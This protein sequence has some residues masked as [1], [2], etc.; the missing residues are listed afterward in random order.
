[1]D[2][3]KKTIILFSGDLDK[4]LAAFIIANGAAASGDDVT[5]FFTFW[6]IN[7]VRKRQKVKAGGKTL[8]QSMFGRM[9]P[10]GYE[11][12]GLSKMN[13]LG[14]GAP[15]MKRLMKQQGAMSIEALI[16]SARELGVRF[17][18]CT[19]SMDLLGFK[20]EE[21][22]DGMEYEGVT[23]YLGTAEEASINLFI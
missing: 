1:V 13:F 14:M 18:I 9:M 6:G 11:A 2:T 23:S 20:K 12:V 7:L 10:R 22:F 5:I 3:T 21:M 19:M 4:A 17:V 15:M 8:L 16:D